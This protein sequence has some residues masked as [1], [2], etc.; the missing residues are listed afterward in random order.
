M[1]V[2]S[3]VNFKLTVINMCKKLDDKMENFGRE[4]ETIKKEANKN[5][6]NAQFMVTEIKS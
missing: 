2:L 6:G 3:G 4:L 5:C 1:L